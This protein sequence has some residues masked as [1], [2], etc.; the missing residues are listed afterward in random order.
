MPITSAVARLLS[1]WPSS[2]RPIRIQLTS[3]EPPP[4]STSNA[5]GYLGIEKVLAPGQRQPCFFLRCNDLEAKTG[6]RLHLVEEVLAIAGAAA[7][8]RRDMAGARD[9]MAVDPRGAYFE[10]TQ[11]AVDGVAAQRPVQHNA[12]AQPDRPGIGVDYLETRDRRP[13]HQQPAIV[14]AEIDGGKSVRETT[15]VPASP[16]SRLWRGIPRSWR[17]YSFG[18]MVPEEKAAGEPAY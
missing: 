16:L 1:P 14:G 6:A 17:S 7:R 9:A 12:F 8:L 15:A 2:R 11:S 3:V 13:R 4:I 5:Y 18:S 10:G